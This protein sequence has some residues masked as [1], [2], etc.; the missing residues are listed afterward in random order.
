MAFFTGGTRFFVS[1][2][3]RSSAIVYAAGCQGEECVIG[4][5]RSF[6]TS[7]HP[8]L[9]ERQEW[10]H[11]RKCVLSGMRTLA[12]RVER[13]GGVGFASATEATSPCAKKGHT[14]S[15]RTPAHSKG[16]AYPHV[17]K[18]SR[19]R[20]LDSRQEKGMPTLESHIMYC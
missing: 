2:S 12:V 15:A 4:R 20:T 16:T 18:G 6:G 7:E 8:T 10:N 14:H 9:H 19:A 13:C 3:H 5:Q 17:A 11:W 1:L